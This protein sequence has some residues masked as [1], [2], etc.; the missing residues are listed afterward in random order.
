[1]SIELNSTSQRLLTEALQELDSLMVRSVKK[2]GEER[3]ES[4]IDKDPPS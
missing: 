3:N 1:M 4:L 2:L